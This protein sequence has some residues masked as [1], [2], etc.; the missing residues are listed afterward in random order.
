MLPR[1]LT[2]RSLSHFDRPSLAPD[3]KGLHLL[4]RSADPAAARFAAFAQ[5]VLY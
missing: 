4:P 1:A 2:A 3:Q 5:A